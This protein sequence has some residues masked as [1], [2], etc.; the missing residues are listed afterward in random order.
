MLN[1]KLL[2]FLVS[3]HLLLYPPKLRSSVTW[4]HLTRCYRLPSLWDSFCLTLLLITCNKGKRVARSHMWTWLCDNFA[5]L[6][7][8]VRPGKS[9]CSASCYVQLCFSHGTLLQSVQLENR[10]ADSRCEDKLEGRPGK[11]W[12]WILSI[13]TVIVKIG[14]LKTE[15]MGNLAST[16]LPPPTPALQKPTGFSMEKRESEDSE[17]W[18]WL[19]HSL[20]WPWV[21]HLVLSFSFLNS[22][23]WSSSQCMGWCVNVNRCL[24]SVCKLWSAKVF[25]AVFNSEVF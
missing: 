13:R 6:K 17:I 5:L 15:S 12:N 25:L 1:I 14:T 24:Q 22:L 4:H 10:R 2:R 9:F 3:C 7:A 19:E 18:R 21:N 20:L 11:S 16:P 8:V 23:K